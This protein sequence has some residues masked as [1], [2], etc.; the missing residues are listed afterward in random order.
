MGKSAIKKAA[1]TGHRS[2]IQYLQSNMIKN[3]QGCLWIPQVLF[4]L[5]YAS[6]HHWDWDALSFSYAA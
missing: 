1:V 2:Q 4:T 6:L 3:K 5:Q